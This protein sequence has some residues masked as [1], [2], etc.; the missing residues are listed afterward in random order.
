MR[1]TTHLIVWHSTHEWARGHDGDGRREVHCNTRE[2]AGTALRTCP[3]SFLG[4]YKQGLHLYMATYKAMANTKRVTAR[5][6]RR[7]C[8]GAAAAH[9]GDT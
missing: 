6:I 8:I 4:I 9:T 1:A 7:M 3:R 2:G 5:L